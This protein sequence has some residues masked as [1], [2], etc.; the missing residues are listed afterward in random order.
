MKELVKLFVGK[1]CLINTINSQLQ[2]VIKE[3][4]DGGIIITNGENTEIINLEYVI[5][6]REYP[7]GKNGKKK[8]FIYD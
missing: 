5:R 4:S 6:V 7:R 2:G 8:T 1:E 3:V